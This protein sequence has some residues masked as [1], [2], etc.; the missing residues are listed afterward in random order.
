MAE[1]LETATG[2]KCSTHEKYDAATAERM[3][4]YKSRRSVFII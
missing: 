2:E 4:T 1:G 3:V